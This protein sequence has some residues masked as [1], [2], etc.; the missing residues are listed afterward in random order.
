M[1]DDQTAH[2]VAVVGAERIASARR[3]EPEHAAARGGDADRPAAVTTVRHRHHAGGDGGRGTAARAARGVLRVPRVAGRPEGARL[4][5]GRDA[6]LRCVGLAENDEPGAP[7]ARHQLAVVVGD[8]GAH[9]LRAVAHRHAGE[10]REQVLHEERN[11]RERSHRRD[12]GGDGPRA[13]EERR[14]HR[15]EGRVGALDA[16]D[17]GIDQLARCDLATSDQ[18]RL[19][20]GVEIAELFHAHTREPPLGANL[21]APHA[22]S[23]NTGARS[24]GRRIRD[25]AGGRSGRGAPAAA[26]RGRRAAVPVPARC[27]CENRR[28]PPRARARASVTGVETAA[29]AVGRTE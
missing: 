6:E 29:L 25:S 1:L 12:A 15:V 26:P 8:V 21:Y 4:G 28:W 2:D 9:H 16:R 18:I 3:L 24:A 27:R 11:A 23:V 20:G 19:R 17:R 22:W 13:L 5:R 14:D 10:A 7:V